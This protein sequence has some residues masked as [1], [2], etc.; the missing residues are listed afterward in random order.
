MES[1]TCCALKIKWGTIGAMGTYFVEQI[2]VVGVIRGRADSA[3]RAFL[4]ALVNT[5]AGIVNYI[6]VPFVAGVCFTMS[7][8]VVTLHGFMFDIENCVVVNV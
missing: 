6:V 7:A 2:V 4:I 3:F 1:Y 5:K 8:P